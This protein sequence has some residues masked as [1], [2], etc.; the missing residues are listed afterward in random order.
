MSDHQEVEEKYKAQI[1]AVAE[2]LDDFLNGTTRPRVVGFAVLMFD[3]GNPTGARMNYISNGERSDMLTAMKEFIARNEG[4][5]I[6][7]ETKQ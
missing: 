1:R 3:F 5:V 4:R 7:T 6:D 2:V